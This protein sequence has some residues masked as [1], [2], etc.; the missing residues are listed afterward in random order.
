MQQRL[1][2]QI[3]LEIIKHIVAHSPYFI[4]AA[5]RNVAGKLDIRQSVE[6]RTTFRRFRILHVE[7]RIQVGAFH[8]SGT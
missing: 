3:A 8:K 5:S 6:R 2:R 1:S 7:N 4:V